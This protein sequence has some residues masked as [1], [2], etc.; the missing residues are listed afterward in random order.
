MLRA[1]IQAL[2]IL[3]IVASLSGCKSNSMTYEASIRQWQHERLVSLTRPDGWVTLVGLYPLEEGT[4]CF[5]SDSLCPV[6]FPAGTPSEMGTMTVQRETVDM[7]INSGIDVEVNGTSVQDIRLE[8]TDTTYVCSFA[9]YQWFLIN[10]GGHFL[11]R[12]RDT[13]HP[14]RKTLKDIPYFPIDSHWR[15]QATFH[16]YDTLRTVPLPNALDMIVDTSSPGYLSFTY[17][18]NTYQLIVL[19][20]GPDELFLLF[21][22]ETS[23]MDTYGGGRYLYTKK[24][25]DG[26]TVVLDFNQAYNPPCAFTTFATCLLPPL[27]NR[28]PFPV[29]AG[30]K[31][32]HFLTH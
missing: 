3:G 25:V 32:P 6:R 16:P 2:I 26:N 11:V 21:Y 28:L 22:D 7:H 1:A 17:Q 8:P 10:R 18:G 5:G 31:D 29:T 23:G 27:E 12:I 30:E 9:S 19:D 14:A 15:F 24:P 20:G 4:Q 13:E